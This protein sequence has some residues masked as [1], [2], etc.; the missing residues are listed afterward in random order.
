MKGKMFSSKVRRRLTPA[1][2]ATSGGLAQGGMNSVDSPNVA[3]RPLL[4]H[5]AVGLAAEYVRHME[6]TTASEVPVGGSE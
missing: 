3:L 6:V 5:I 1:K 4:D 2:L